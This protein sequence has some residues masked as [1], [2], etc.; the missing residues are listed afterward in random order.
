MPPPVQCPQVD[1]GGYIQNGK[2]RM[3]PTTAA[4]ISASTTTD[5]TTTNGPI[6]AV[7][8]P[9]PLYADPALVTNFHDMD[10]HPTEDSLLQANGMV[11]RAMAGLPVGE[12]HGGYNGRLAVEEEMRRGS[13]ASSNGRRF[14]R[15]PSSSTSP[16]DAMGGGREEPAQGQQT[17]G[18]R[19]RTVSN[20]GSTSGGSNAGS[21]AAAKAKRKRS[22]I[23]CKNCN[24]RRVRCDGSIT[25]LPC[26][27]CK[28]AGR[29]D[30]AFIDSKRVR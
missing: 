9:H 30:C 28:A 26:T 3:L 13:E 17:Q 27:T 18:V 25:G 1:E 16:T 8:P 6:L 22:M 7:P 11:Q 29:T 14:E 12:M 5:S 21:A 10:H 15:S 20:A 23:A 4:S 2:A 19:F 24:E